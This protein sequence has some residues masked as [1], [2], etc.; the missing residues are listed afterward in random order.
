MTS[1]IMRDLIGLVSGGGSRSVEG[2]PR[3]ELSEDGGRFVRSAK[4]ERENATASA[5]AGN[6]I[7]G[8]PSA[9]LMTGCEQVVNEQRRHSAGA[10]LPQK[11]RLSES[12]IEGILGGSTR[13][14]ADTTN[15][16]REDID[17]L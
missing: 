9:R 3:V 7:G 12:R 11:R 1:R 6:D 15:L 8:M 13:D 5:A 14:T 16:R 4:S 2:L 10:R 17:G